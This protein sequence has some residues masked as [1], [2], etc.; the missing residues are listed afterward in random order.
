MPV[1]QVLKV[2]QIKEVHKLLSEK[3]AR[4]LIIAGGTD[5]C[6]KL[7]EGHVQADTLVDISDVKELRTLS[8]WVDIPSI[9]TGLFIGAGVT[10]SEIVESPLFKEKFN[11]LWTACR[12]VG[13]PQIRNRG[14]VGGNLANGSPAADAAPPLLALNA[15]LKLSSSEGSRWVDLT[16]FYLDKGRTVLKADELLEGILIPSTDGDYIHR[17]EKLGLRNALAISRLSLS[18]WMQLDEEKIIRNLRI[19][20]GSLGLSP[21][22]EPLLEAFLMGKPFNEETISLGAEAFSNV[23]QERL[24]GRSTCPFKKEAIKGVFR[25]LMTGGPNEA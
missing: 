21:M 5:V 13:A 7:R 16:D 20:S 14:T 25:A 1:E 22:R 10:F 3:G 4:A 15:K 19:A 23:V 12:S 11:G 6:V 18:V 8:E 24:A 17:F 2:S 9:G